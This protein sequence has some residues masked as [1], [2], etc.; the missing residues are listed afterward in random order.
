MRMRLNDVLI[1]TPKKLD[2][3]QQVQKKYF[4]NMDQLPD[5]LIHLHADS[6][7]RQIIYRDYQIRS[8]VG[9]IL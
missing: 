6:F 5:N 4:D 7:T 3:V 9:E 1:R 8:A 2:I